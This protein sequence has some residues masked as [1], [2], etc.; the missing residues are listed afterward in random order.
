MPINI[1]ELLNHTVG[2]FN[3]SFYT[4]YQGSSAILSEN[5]F[6]LSDSVHYI[7][8]KLYNAWFEGFSKEKDV[9]I[10]GNN[11]N[12]TSKID[13]R[14]SLKCGEYACYEKSLKNGKICTPGRLTHTLTPTRDALLNFVTRTR[15]T[16][17]CRAAPTSSLICHESSKLKFDIPKFI[18]T[19]ST[20]PHFSAYRANKG[21]VFCY[22]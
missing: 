20:N 19:R 16:E 17:K 3:D 15:C 6:A 9:W 22:F 8:R 18:V 14:K 1:S 7:Y 5:I 13:A 12:D 11:F 10:L 2:D 21:Q 4:E